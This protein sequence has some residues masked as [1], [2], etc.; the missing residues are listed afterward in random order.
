MKNI[1]VEI[2]MGGLNSRLD[3]AENY[4]TRRWVWRNYSEYKID[5]LGDENPLQKLEWEGLAY[6]KIYNLE[7]NFT[8]YNF[9]KYIPIVVGPS[10]LSISGTLSSP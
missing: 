2:S 8:L 1:R 3:T 7:N 10:P 4:W 9:I 6:W 5:R